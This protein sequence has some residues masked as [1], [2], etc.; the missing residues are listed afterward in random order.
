MAVV[1]RELSSMVHSLI[2]SGKFILHK[3]PTRAVSKHISSDNRFSARAG[4]PGGGCVSWYS[5]L[6][7]AVLH[8]M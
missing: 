8:S 3:L 2:C 6:G 5:H 7:G 1:R 4:T